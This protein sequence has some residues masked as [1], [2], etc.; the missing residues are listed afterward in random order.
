MNSSVLGAEGPSGA[1]WGR[2][3]ATRPRRRL[4][5]PMGESEA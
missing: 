1:V 3:E 2:L 4:G 5:D